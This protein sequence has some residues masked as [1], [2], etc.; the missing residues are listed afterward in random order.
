MI[1]STRFRAGFFP[2]LRE[3]RK[4]K[5]YDTLSL[6]KGEGKGEGFLKCL[7]NNVSK[8]LKT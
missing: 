7:L 5:N 3:E 2:L 6:F 4:V 8:F 1:F